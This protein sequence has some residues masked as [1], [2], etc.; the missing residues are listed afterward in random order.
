[1]T[2]AYISLFLDILLLGF[3]S[4]TLFH[5]FRLSKALTGF[6]LQR[7]EF[8]SVITNLLASID[9]AERSVQ[10]LKTVS[11]K[12]SGHLEKLIEQSKSLS[13]ELKIINEAG[14]SMANRLEA[15][16]EKNRKMVQPGGYNAP[17]RKLKKS[18]PPT[19]QR[20]I[21]SPVPDKDKDKDKDKELGRE[22]N[23]AQ[24]LRTMK[25]SAQ[26]EMDETDIPSFMI[27][28]REAEDNNLSNALS[29]EDGN[30]GAS[31]GSQAEK[32]LFDAIRK[33]KQDI[34]R[35]GQS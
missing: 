24:T 22:K 26:S 17:R 29:Q 25:P 32:E 2:T 33:S 13:E 31:L 19:D 4:V 18:S 21:S 6:K 8:D 16:A 5:I 35:R 27:Q 1:M 3:L 7:K 11:S 28:D 10:I 23:Y 14:E 15:L 20:K 9:Q 12:E 34:Y 30:D